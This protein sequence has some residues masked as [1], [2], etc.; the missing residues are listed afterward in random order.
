VN[1]AYPPG[2]WSPFLTNHDHVRVMNQLGG[3]VAKAKVAAMAMLMLPG[4]P[5]VY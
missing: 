4:M 3:D 1:A 2:R 5:F